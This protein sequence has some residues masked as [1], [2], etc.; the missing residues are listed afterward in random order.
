MIAERSATIER[1]DRGA[2]NDYDY[3]IVTKSL[4]KNST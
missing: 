1:F 3:L 2:I 4:C